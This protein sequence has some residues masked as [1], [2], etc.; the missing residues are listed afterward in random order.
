MF[1]IDASSSVPPFEQLRDQVVE[2]VSSGRLAAG[3][4]LPTVRGLAIDLGIAANTVARAYRELEASGI[5][6][7][8]GR[9]GSFVAAQGDV[10]EQRGQQA[11]REY[12]ESIRKLGIDTDVALEWAAA[13]L[14]S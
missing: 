3:A 10:V 1:R 4:K 12:A 9:A 7:T 14:R 2:Q 5:I 6:E 8:R 11:A 13:A